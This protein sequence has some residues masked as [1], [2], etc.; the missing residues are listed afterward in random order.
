M[1]CEE[2]IALGTEIRWNH[3]GAPLADSLAKRGYPTRRTL[4][5]LFQNQQHWRLVYDPRFQSEQRRTK[6][7][8]KRLVNEPDEEVVDDQLEATMFT[9]LD[10]FKLD[11]VWD[12][13][14][15]PAEG[16]EICNGWAQNKRIPKLEKVYMD[17]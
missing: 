13:N 17:R 6:A 4:E 10:W 12:A 9:G 2:L 5:L 16:C 8:L 1:T 14:L 11:A 3:G 7:K 15:E